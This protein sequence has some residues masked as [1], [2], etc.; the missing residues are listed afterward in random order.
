M[1]IFYMLLHG[2]APGKNGTI[3][4]PIQTIKTIIYGSQKMLE[5]PGQKVMKDFRKRDSVEEWE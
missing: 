4:V 1:R 5:N 2:S 3:H